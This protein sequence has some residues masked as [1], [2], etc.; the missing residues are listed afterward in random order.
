M[1]LLATLKVA[2]H[3]VMHEN[4]QLDEFFRL[5]L[6]SVEHVSFIGYAERFDDERFG[7]TRVVGE[8][9]G[10][11]KKSEFL[12]GE[13]YLGH[14]VATGKRGYWTNVTKDPRGTFFERQGAYLESIMCYPVFQEQEVIGVLFGG[15]TADVSESVLDFFEL[16]SL[17]FG[18][19]MRLNSLEGNLQVRTVR[20]AALLELSQAIRT[21]EDIKN[22]LYIILD[23]S[24]NLVQGPFS[25]IVFQPSDRN[26]AIE[27]ITRGIPRQQAADYGRI[28]VQSYIGRSFKEL[29]DEKMPSIR[30]VQGVSVIECPLYVQHQVI[31][32]LAV[33]V[34]V[35]EDANEFTPLMHALSVIGGAALQRIYK[36]DEGIREISLAHRISGFWSREAHHT[37]LEMQEMALAFGKYLGLADSI[38]REI[39]LAAL[40]TPYDATFVEET[41]TNV[42]AGV[43]QLISDYQTAF[44][45]DHSSQSISHYASQILVVV[46][47]YVKQMDIPTGLIPIELHENFERYILQSRVEN[48]EIVLDETPRTVS[49]NQ[50]LIMETQ[51]LKQLTA[52]ERDILQ[53][54]VTGKG[55]RDI[56]QT[57]FISE[58]TVKNHMTNIFQK[59]GVTDR[60][61]AIALVLRQ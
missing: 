22:L 37:A 55:N 21:V 41:L 2:T 38:S 36:A 48:Q 33:G 45:A 25:C 23:M 7:I 43:L 28:L 27:L 3:I 9:A 8:H 52:R 13:G 42:P 32:V 24:L 50:S 54:L 1:N 17:M 57:L 26:S 14:V 34:N 39:G 61:Q 40:L 12:I 29:A 11:L 59:L 10:E 56:A 60:T 20:L 58:H 47:S 35:T 16:V 4:S 51:V 19:Q 31:A 6:S 44:N 15:L 30:N 53:L 49:D 46:A 18:R 5:L